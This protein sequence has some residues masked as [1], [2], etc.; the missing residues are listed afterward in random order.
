MDTLMLV[1]VSLLLAGLL[2]VIVIKSVRWLIKRKKA[3][4]RNDRKGGEQ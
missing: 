3:E 4:K 1:L 2:S